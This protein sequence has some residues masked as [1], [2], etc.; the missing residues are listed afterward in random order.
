RRVEGRSSSLAYVSR[1]ARTT[2][3]D[4]A[5]LSAE[6]E[7]GCVIG[8]ECG[9]SVVHEPVTTLEISQ[10]RGGLPPLRQPPDR[11]GGHCCWIDRKLCVRTNADHSIAWSYH[12]PPLHL[13]DCNL[14]PHTVHLLSLIGD[15]N[16]F[17]LLPLIH[18]QLD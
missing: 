16:Y 2:S 1:C 10:D 7:V 13:H 3:G 9:S 5:G 15:L 11:R 8:H 14:P 18:S 12:H 17:T 6:Y 4:L